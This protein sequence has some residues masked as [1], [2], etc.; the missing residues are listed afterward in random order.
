MRQILFDNVKQRLEEIKYGIETIDDLNKQFE[1]RRLS[2]VSHLSPTEL[3]IP[4]IHALKKNRIVILAL[5]FGQFIEVCF[6]Q[7]KILRFR[8]FGQIEEN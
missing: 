5:Q 2:P 8:L 1:H 3:P 6:Y 7:Q 4:A